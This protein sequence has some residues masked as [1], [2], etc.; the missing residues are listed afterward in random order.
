MK[1]PKPRPQRLL[2]TG[3]REARP[4][5]QEAVWL[6]CGGGN[7]ITLV[8]DMLRLRERTKYRVSEKGRNTVSERKVETPFLSEKTTYRLKEGGTVVP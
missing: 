8:N 5:E 7:D 1:L 3:R 2:R 4:W 6:F